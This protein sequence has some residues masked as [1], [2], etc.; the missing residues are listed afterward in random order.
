MLIEKLI[1]QK[2]R[3]GHHHE[4]AK[5]RYKNTRARPNKNK[6][7]KK[8][9]PQIIS[10][11][12][13]TALPSTPVRPYAERHQKT[14]A[15]AHKSRATRVCGVVTRAGGRGK[16]NIPPTQPSS[17]SSFPLYEK[18]GD[19]LERRVEQK[20]EEVVGDHRSETGLGL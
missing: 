13:D 2:G 5:S 20:S 10:V 14:K 3:G 4:E 18:E 15:S 19:S 16:E 17:L 6:K 7:R 1:V 12:I 11:T 8:K 9:T